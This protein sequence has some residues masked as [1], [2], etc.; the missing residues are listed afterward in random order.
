MDLF[1]GIGTTAFLPKAIGMA[2]GLRFRNGIETQQVEC[3]HGPIGHRG[4]PG[5]PQFS[6]ALGNVHPAERLRLV[7]VPTQARKAADLASGVF[8]RTSST[9]GVFAP[10]LPTTRR[11]ARARPLN[12]CVSR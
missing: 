8:Q 9:P 6:I 1:Q 11:M 2:V 10:E 7:T 4:N 5:T 12:E 3:L